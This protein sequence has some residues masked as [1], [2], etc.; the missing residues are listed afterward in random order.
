MEERL[1]A[2]Y[3]REYRLLGR[4]EVGK[5]VGYAIMGFGLLAIGLGIIAAASYL[6]KR[7]LIEEYINEAELYNQSLLN[8]WKDGV[9]DEDEEKFLNHLQFLLERKEDLIRSSGLENALASAVS[10]IFG[11]PL[12]ILAGGYVTAKLIRELGKRYRPPRYT[13]PIDGEEFRS[14][15]ELKRHL[16]EDHSATA[17]VE[18]YSTLWN[19]FQ[20]TPNTFKGIVADIMGWTWEQINRGVEWFN[21]LP[22][23]QK[24]AIGIALAIA[25]LLAIAFAPWLAG[26]AGIARVIQLALAVFA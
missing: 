17:E 3:R 2:E 15:D 7:K 21:S 9:I 6:S 16:Q 24:I 12:A 22:L 26:I 14:E 19:E 18:Q 11:I 5:E 4:L 13:C 1:P 8:A 23:E 25:I 20:Q 10:N